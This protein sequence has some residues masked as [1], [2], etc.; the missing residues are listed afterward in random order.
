M[1]P[2]HIDAGAFLVMTSDLILKNDGKGGM[3]YDDPIY[4]YKQNLEI[5]LPS[6]ERVSFEIPRKKLLFM[7][8]RGFSNWGIGKQSEIFWNPVPHRVFL[9]KN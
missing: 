5:E 7:G 1:R 6:G 9:T 3:K 8:G 2:L 4:F